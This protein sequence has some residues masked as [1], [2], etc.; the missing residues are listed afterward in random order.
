MALIH[1]KRLTL[2]PRI[3]LRQ[4]NAREYNQRYILKHIRSLHFHLVIVRS[5]TNALIV[6]SEP[7]DES[8]TPSISRISTAICARFAAS[9]TR[10]KSRRNGDVSCL[11]CGGGGC[12][13]GCCFGADV[14]PLDVEEVEEEVGCEK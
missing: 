8:A 3:S 5:L 13:A 7:Y 2:C 4:E 6:C 1:P 11:C 12:A 10:L 14:G 9:A